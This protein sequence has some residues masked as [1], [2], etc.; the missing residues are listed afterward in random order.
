MNKILTF[1]QQRPVRE[2]CMAA[3]AALLLLGQT[4]NWLILEPLE[5][6]QHHQTRRLEEARHARTLLNSQ[7]PGLLALKQ[8]LPTQRHT[9]LQDVL[10]DVASRHKLPLKPDKQD[11]TQLSL[12]P[13][14]LSFPELIAVLQ[15]LEQQAGIQ[16]QEI[17]IFAADGLVTV[18]KMVVQ[19]H[20]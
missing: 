1:W 14:S 20:D 13:F 12:A 8:Q 10:A 2:R 4:A 7:L 6:Y 19:R 9:E 17:I 18:K 11:T 3:V 15:Q 5:R 16:A